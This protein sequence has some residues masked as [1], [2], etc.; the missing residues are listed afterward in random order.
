[1]VKAK[2]W[3]RVTAR[4]M[5]AGDTYPDPKLGPCRVVS[6]TP[7]RPI[8]TVVI[9]RDDD[10]RAPAPAPT[11]RS[12]TVQEVY[13]ILT[14]IGVSEGTASRGAYKI[15]RASTGQPIKP[16]DRRGAAPT[17]PMTYGRDDLAED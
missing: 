15:V 4:S 2:T 6:F 13:D 14:S 10:R 9:C 17:V 7:G 8:N 5:K 12:L 16:S 11:V 1:M 3:T